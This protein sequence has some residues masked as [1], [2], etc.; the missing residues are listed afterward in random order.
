MTLYRTLGAAC[1]LAAC[2]LKPAYAD[3]A[4]P[5]FGGDAGGPIHTIQ[6]A[7]LPQGSL[8][9][10][11]T[12]DYTRTDRFSDDELATLAG[13]H[14]H[15][16]SVDWMLTTSLAVNYGVSDDFT[17]SVRMPSVHRENVRAGSHTHGGG[18]VVVNEAVD[19]GD[20]TGYGDLA[21][22]GKY[23]FWKGDNCSAAVLVG[24]KA[25][26]GRT[27]VRDGAQKLEAEHQPGS[28]SWDG[29]FGLALGTRIGPV[30]LNASTLYTKATRGSQGT[31]LG[32]RA[33]YGVAVS[34][35][36]GGETHDHGDFVHQHRAWDPVLELNGEWADQMEIDDAREDHSGGNT[37]F[38]A[39]GLR[40][41]PDEKWAAHLSVGVPVISNLGRG[42]AETDYKM[43]LGVS[44]S[45]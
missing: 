3:H 43:T 38:V 5:G 36:I 45:F 32:D 37:I 21:A 2:A 42:H 30:A 29:L 33:Q 11:L 22:L 14:V 34:Y 28:G 40:Y 24:L 13:R 44:R 4:S 17:L 12:S 31:D 26:T 9:A 15:A 8:T 23:R 1:L 35:R 20:S 6:A 19:H 25:P 39:P 41:A 16:H 10:G 7:T 18:G 27:D